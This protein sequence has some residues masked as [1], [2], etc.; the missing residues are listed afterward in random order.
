MIL[1][2]KKIIQYLIFKYKF[3]YMKYNIRQMNITNIYECPKTPTSTY[4]NIYI[5]RYQWGIRKK[6]E[7]ND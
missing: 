1:Q 5:E 4:V 2:N 3:L 7:I 6:N